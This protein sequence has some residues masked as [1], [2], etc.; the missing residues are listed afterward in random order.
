MHKVWQAGLL[1][2]LVASGFS[3]LTLLTGC[4]RAKAEAV[5]LSNEGD[6]TKKG[7]NIEG[8]IAKWKEAAQL[9]PDNHRVQWRLVQ[10]YRKK[11]DWDNA[12]SAAVKAQHADEKFNSKKTFAPYWFEQGY[13]LSKLA[14]T[15]KGKWA[16]AKQPLE[17]AVQID[18]NFAAAYFELA[19]VLLRMD[20]EGAEKGAIENYNKAIEKNPKDTDFYG[21]LAELY[22]NLN[23]IPQAEQVLKEGLPFAKEGDKRA[24][25]LRARLGQVLE[26]KGDLSGAIREYEAAKKA[27]GA[28]DDHKDVHFLLGAAYF[29]ANPPRKN[30]ASSEL[31][32]FHKGACKGASAVRYRSE[33]DQALEFSRKLGTNL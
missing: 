10:A 29:A 7:G 30:E 3:S 16:D 32:R 4:D 14:A 2:G 5:E 6:M 18:P 25:D 27:C 12:I 33:C 13:A 1:A 22:F 26:L 31:Q 17:T 9:D 11:E 21:P 19:Q 20:E 8:A 24:Y 15:G 28:C 23:F